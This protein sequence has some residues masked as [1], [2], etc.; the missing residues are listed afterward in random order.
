VEWSGASALHRRAP[1]Q[2]V[3]AGP[4]PAP[5]PESA[6]PYVVDVGALSARDRDDAMAAARAVVQ[7][8]PNESFSRTMME[9]WLAGTFVLANGASA[10]S[11][12]HC[13]RSGAGAVYDDEAEFAG[14]MER[15]ADPAWSSPDDAGRAYVL[16]E[17]TWP[18]VLD[19]VEVLL[20]E[21]FPVGGD[22]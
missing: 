19:R 22:A 5:I 18:V 13:D 10:V 7:P 8:S 3:V 15:I 12:W 14:W 20:D 21:W 17:Y 16:R 1:L 9:A 6:T 11:R 4:G 2:L